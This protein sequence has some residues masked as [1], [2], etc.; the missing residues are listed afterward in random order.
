M[1]RWHKVSA[2][3]QNG[4]PLPVEGFADT[5]PGD[6][7]LRGLTGFGSGDTPGELAAYFIVGTADER[8]QFWSTFKVWNEIT[9]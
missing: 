5:S 7:A 4:A 6:I 1:T 8:R 2:F 9:E 3:F